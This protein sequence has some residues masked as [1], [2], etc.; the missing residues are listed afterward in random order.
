MEEKHATGRGWYF[1]IGA[2]LVVC[3]L[4]FLLAPMLAT[5]AAGLAFGGLLVI[6]GAAQGIIAVA[7]RERGWVASVLLGLLAMGAGLLMLTDPV[8]GVV[9][10][11]LLLAA[12]LLVSG[13]V[14][15]VLSAMWSPRRGWGWMLFN[16]GI[17]IL[18]GL[19]I[20]SGWPGTGL[21]T[22]GVFLGVDA[23]LAGF[24]RIAFALGAEAPGLH[25]AGPRAPGGRS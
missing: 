15:T 17:T 21:W 9:G 14:R 23:L 5:V 2:F 7:T 13:V 12:F 11:T 10:I 24:A 22:I 1:L 4:A 19:A 20:L 8:A 18:L 25:L 16:G 3:G 6:A